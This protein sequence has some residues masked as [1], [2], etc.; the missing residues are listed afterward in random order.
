M[1]LLIREEKKK[2]EMGPNA[3]IKIRYP[4]LAKMPLVPSIDPPTNIFLPPPRGK[5]RYSSHQSLVQDIHRFLTTIP[6]EPCEENATDKE[7]NSVAGTT[8]LELFCIFDLMGFNTECTKEAYAATISRQDEEP[9]MKER[10]DKWIAH[11]LQHRAASKAGLKKPLAT[12][13]ARKDLS[14]ELSTFIRVARYVV[15]TSGSA[16]AADCFQVKDDGYDNRMSYLAISG[17]HATIRANCLVPDDIT[18][19]VATAIAMH[20]TG[21][22]TKTHTMY[23]AYQKDKLVNREALF[24]MPTACITLRGPPRWRSGPMWP[25]NAFCQTPADTNG[26]M[27]TDGDRPKRRMPKIDWL[28]KVRTITKSVL[29]QTTSFLVDECPASNFPS[30]SPRDMPVD[31]DCED[32]DLMDMPLDE[33]D[34]NMQTLI[35]TTQDDHMDNDE[36]IDTTFIAG[37]A[38]ENP[39]SS[40]TN[41]TRALQEVETPTQPPE[42]KIARIFDSTNTTGGLTFVPVQPVLFGIAQDADIDW[43][44][45][46]V[47][48]IAK[49]FDKATTRHEQATISS[50]S[51]DQLRPVLQ[52]RDTT[53]EHITRFFT[54]DH[55]EL[56]TT[57][58]DDTDRELGQTGGAFGCS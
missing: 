53:Q 52:T 19:L 43:K 33:E 34:A 30:M 2:A 10:N 36:C 29:T 7:K 5:H 24:S 17:N 28:A 9:R 54:S 51:T 42:P 58:D 38:E 49:F 1:T 48:D 32:R 56:V 18:T 57:A 41:L 27:T 31:S 21:H 8:W 3:K 12:A 22:T 6:M 47:Y 13:E 45:C 4:V 14:M 20:R 44:P 55:S 37:P 11:R 15:R 39:G 46:N 16:E 26:N 40:A 23:K 50:S 25:P 35:H